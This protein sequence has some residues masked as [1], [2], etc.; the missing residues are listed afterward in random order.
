MIFR[1]LR[2]QHSPSLLNGESVQLGSLERGLE[3]GSAASK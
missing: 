1:V 2:V 3:Q